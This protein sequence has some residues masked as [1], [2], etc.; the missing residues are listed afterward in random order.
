MIESGLKMSSMEWPHKAAVSKTGFALCSRRPSRGCREPPV[1]AFL[2][3]PSIPT[4]IFET[5]S[6]SLE[7]AHRHLTCHS[8]F[9]IHVLQEKAWT[10]SGW[11]GLVSSFESSSGTQF[12]VPLAQVNRWP[13]FRVHFW[14]PFFGACF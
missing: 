10:W 6:E 8:F 13:L 12:Q 5:F 7:R 4:D 9:P 3:W 2:W 14:H 11:V 1:F